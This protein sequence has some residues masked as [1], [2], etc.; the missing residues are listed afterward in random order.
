MATQVVKSACGLCLGFC[1]VL[2]T[3]ENGKPVK[4]EGDPEHPG[5]MGSL[6]SKGMA[7]LEYLY[8]PDRLKHPLRRAAG[9]GEGKWQQISWEE[10]LGQ[11]AEE[12]NELR[13]RYG[14]ESV[15][16]IHGSA[17]GYQDT[18][19]KRFA[20]AFGTPNLATADHV[21]HVPRVLASEL[22]CG[23][24]PEADLMHPPAC[25]VA[26]GTNNAETRF[27]VYD[28]FG[29]ALGKG[30]RLIVIDSMTIEAAK[31]AEL[32]LRPR[33]G[34]DLAL[35][36][37][38]I[39]VIINEDLFEKPFVDNWTIGFDELKAHI[40]DYPPERV[41]E[42][43]WIG[44]GAIREAARFYATNKPGVI[45]WGNSLDHNLNSFQ[46][47]RA[48]SI[49]KA[50]TGN[51][52]VPGGEIEASKVDLLGYWSPELE[53][54]GKLPQDNW[55]KR[56][57]AELKLLPNFH[58]TIP[59]CVVKAII[60]ED[61]YP[62]RGAYVQGSNPLLSWSNA[63]EVYRAFKKLKFFAAAD[64]FM[65]PTVALADVVL[66]VAS[67]LEFDGIVSP[68][69]GTSAHIQ[70]KVG[71]VGE[72]R[73]DHAILNDLARKLGLKEYF[74][75]SVDDFWNAILKPSGLTFEAF[76]KIGRISG[77]RQYGTYE[78]DGFKT[79][80]GKV[81]LVSSQLKECNLDPLPTYREMPE[82]PYSD[83]ELSEEYPFIF[84]SRKSAPYRHSGGRQ[85]A[86]LRNERPEPTV[87]IHPKRAEELG[88]ADGDWVYI[89]T[90]RG[91]IRQKAI[92]SKSVDPR[93]V[94]VD[95][96]WWFPEKG[97]SNL[98]DWAESNINVLTDN[99]PPHSR[100]I[101]SSNLRGILCR[102]YRA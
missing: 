100:E 72:C 7:S 78:R 16:M 10:A 18:H 44:A 63:L 25:I 27:F 102:I 39:N 28:K 24:F 26:W 68:P 31:R 30:A 82:T 69:Q 93:V 99:K 91:R 70:Q 11:I 34:S 64:L 43:T 97:P 4:I 76:K 98:F 23:F 6:C 45:L 52:G 81:E 84:T 21:C 79:P 50:I 61:P 58:A 36:L 47:A 8:H 89:E 46:T 56:V 62:I 41:G 19:L 88:I 1:G 101:G 17:K 35:A 83:P 40:Q 86:S 9:R 57:G 38:L 74:W 95:Y 54:R 66:P 13:T 20:N 48:I 90:R 85:I 49:L 60:E 77:K 42:I 75:D 53:L 22:S 92:L 59:Q 2:I 37:G 33:P 65:T 55:Q 5:N 80:S 32:C 73:S 94:G 51:L 12:L 29:E 87:N 14:P 67:Y 3:L 15:A 71:Q 96:A